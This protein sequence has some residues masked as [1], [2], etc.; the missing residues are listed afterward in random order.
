MARWPYPGM[1]GARAGLV[2][3]LLVVG[4][5][6]IAQRGV[7]TNTVIKHFHILEQRLPRLGLRR[8]PRV[9][10]Q[11]GLQTPEETLH[12]RVVIAVPLPAHASHQTMLLK[13][14]PIVVAGV[15]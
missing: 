13:H 10:H 1:V 9:M 15:L 14:Q 12:D 2:E 11:L 6:P 8:K 5:A 7:T 3:G 4:R